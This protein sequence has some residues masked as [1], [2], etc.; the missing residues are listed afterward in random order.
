[1]QETWVQSL[2]RESALEQ[3]MANPVQYSCLENSM[4]RGAWWAA[5]HGVTKD[6]T[7]LRTHTYTHELHEYIFFCL[8]FLRT[9]PMLWLSRI[10]CD[11]WYLLFLYI[12]GRDH[13]LFTNIELLCSLLESKNSSPC[14]CYQTREMTLKTGQLMNFFVFS[15]TQIGEVIKL[16]N[17]C[18]SWLMPCDRV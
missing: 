8:L 3:E 17:G 16:R 5:A 4:D 15:S 11:S 2:G 18:C 12:L 10:V 6:Q 1:M 9:Q 13:F 7:P 14:N